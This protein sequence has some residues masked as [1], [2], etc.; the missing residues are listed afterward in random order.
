[1]RPALGNYDVRMRA[2]ALVLLV[3]AAC[4]DGPGGSDGA[5]GSGGSEPAAGAPGGGAPGTGGSAGGVATPCGAYC[6]CMSDTCA[7]FDAYPYADEAACLTACEGFTTEELGC[8][9]SF[10]EN[11]STGTP[12]EHQCEHAWG[13]GGTSEC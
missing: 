10:C 11:A 13:D 7:S 1:M 8:F 2:L 5:G 9:G 4:D 12:T 3:L 6:A